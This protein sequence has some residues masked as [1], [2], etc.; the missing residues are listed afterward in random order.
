MKEITLST[1]V[2]LQ[3]VRKQSIETKH[4]GTITIHLN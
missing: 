1:T 4:L 3:Y 2:I